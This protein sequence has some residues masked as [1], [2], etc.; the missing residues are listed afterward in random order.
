MS[1]SNLSA[2][3]VPSSK[4]GGAQ[5]ARVF[6]YVKPRHWLLLLAITT[7]SL[8][9]R[10]YGSQMLGWNWD[11]A[12]SFSLVN[13]DEASSCRTVLAQSPVYEK[14]VGAV[15]LAIAGTLGKSPQAD[16][17]DYPE[18]YFLKAEEKSYLQERAARAH[19][20][21]I[22]A[23]CHS[24]GYLTVA[25]GYSAILGGLT[26]L[27]VGV[28]GFLLVPQSPKIGLTAASLLALSGFHAGQSLM[29]TLDAPSVFCIYL[30]I[31][32]SVLHFRMGRG[33][34]IWLFPFALYL[35]ITT[36]EWPF[37]LLIL[38]AFVPNGAWLYVMQGFSMRRFV[39]ALVVAAAALGLIT[40]IDPAVLPL[41]LLAIAVYSLLIPWL[42]IR[43][44]MIFVWLG[45]PLVLLAMLGS[46]LVDGFFGRL[47]GTYLFS[48]GHGAGFA[49]IGSHKILRNL[50]SFPISIV[51]G[52]GAIATVCIFFGAKDLLHERD[53]RNVWLFFLPVLAYAAY[54]LFVMPTTYYR[55]YLVLIPLSALVAAVGFWRLR[56]SSMPVIKALFFFWPALL[57]YDIWIDYLQDP[58]AETRQW[59]QKAKPQRVYMSFY[60]VPPP[61][62]MRNHRL[63][64]PE[65][66]GGDARGLR[67]AE[68]LVLSENWYDTAF[69]NEINGPFINDLNKLPVTKP[70][71]AQFYRAALAGHHPLLTP[72]RLFPVR[73]FMPEAVLHK[74]LYGTF[75]MFVGDIWILKIG[76]RE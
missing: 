46:G 37:A 11:G 33:W 62:L 66:A 76:R 21:K 60:T 53:D 32:L 69:R 41:A 22:K 54:L 4:E 39:A 42:K 35:A 5:L 43:R 31:M 55:H 38:A 51:M 48:H 64:L 59:Y 67:Q 2:D 34:V 52:V 28:L 1:L 44:T 56:A 24:S 10:I 75:Q 20:A 18:G 49:Q 47:S 50:L 63:F 30:L 73:N 72:Y 68:Y 61:A 15:T 65:Y 16:I 27:I 36:K 45:V 26:A 74:A 7:F 17:F 3:L 29:A 6:S 13:F 14:H 70:E 58:R 23:Y 9:P 12:G 71:Y 19:G 40:N 8:V 57:G 25:R